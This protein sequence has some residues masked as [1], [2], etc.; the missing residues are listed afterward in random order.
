MCATNKFKFGRTDNDQLLEEMPVSDK[1]ALINVEKYPFTF[2]YN[3]SEAKN[4]VL[5]CWFLIK[6]YFGYYQKQKRIELSLVQ[7]FFVIIAVA[8]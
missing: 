3:V 1:H 4:N 8:F 7:S 5:N 2:Y 6:E